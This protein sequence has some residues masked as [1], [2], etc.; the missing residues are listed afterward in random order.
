[1]SYYLLIPVLQSDTERATFTSGRSTRR[2]RRYAVV[3]CSV[4]RAHATSTTHATFHHSSLLFL[5]VV[6]SH[7]HCARQINH[8]FCVKENGE[9]RRADR[10]KILLRSA[11]VVFYTQS[12]VFMPRMLGVRNGLSSPVCSF[13]PPLLCFVSPPV[14]IS[15]RRRN[16]HF[17]LALY[18]DEQNWEA[19]G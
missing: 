7:C 19:K 17:T 13:S 1:M 11:L 15:Q 5:P 9:L 14:T 2:R 4:E 16:L 10:R 18:M 8:D 3:I 6:R 12:F